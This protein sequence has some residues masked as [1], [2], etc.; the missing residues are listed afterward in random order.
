METSECIIDM[1]A[2]VFDTNKNQSDLFSKL[3][4]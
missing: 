4:H 1:Y 2:L 3:S